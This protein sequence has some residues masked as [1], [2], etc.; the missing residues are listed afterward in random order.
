MKLE[1]FKERVKDYQLLEPGNLR[2]KSVEEYAETVA[3][4]YLQLKNKEWLADEYELDIKSFVRDL[5]GKITCVEADEFSGWNGSI[6]IHKLSDFD[7]IL[8]SYTSVLRDK[9]TLAHEMGHYF[10]HFNIFIISLAT[11]RKWQQE[12]GQVRLSGKQTGSPLVY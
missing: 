5:G 8:P 11:K 1:E 6:Y 12:W 4:K 9:F 7:I 2:K 10:L 3:K